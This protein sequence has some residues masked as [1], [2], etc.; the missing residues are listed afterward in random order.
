[1]RLLDKYCRLIFIETIQ[2]I[3]PAAIQ[4]VTLSCV[5]IQLS[6]SMPKP[7]EVA[8]RWQVSESP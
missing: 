8:G 5:L 2:K 3:H 7:L 1:M 6:G 4:P